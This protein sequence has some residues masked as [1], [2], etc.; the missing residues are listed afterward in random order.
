MRT[1][2]SLLIVFGLATPVAAFAEDWKGVTLIDKACGAKFAANP[3]KHPA[4]CLKKCAKKGEALGFLTS[5][6]T[7]LK[8]DKNGVKQ[9]QNAIKHAKSDS[10]RVDVT[11]DKSGDTVKVKSLKLAS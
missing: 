2:L 3:E 4:D 10:I 6:G 1:L 11:G 8:L 5:D 7:W 9:A